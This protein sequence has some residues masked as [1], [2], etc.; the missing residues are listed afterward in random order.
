VL[1]FGVLTTPLELGVLEMD[2]LIAD[3]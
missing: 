1:P 2:A 3:S